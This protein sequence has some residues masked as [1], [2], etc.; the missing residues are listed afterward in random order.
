MFCTNIVHRRRMHCTP[1]IYRYYL[2]HG[3]EFFILFCTTAIQTSPMMLWLPFCS[4]NE[5]LNA[6]RTS[7][8]ERGGGV[9]YDITYKCKKFSKIPK[10]LRMHHMRTFIWLKCLYD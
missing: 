2:K 6:Y 5:I 3:E 10:K 8:L 7:V 4:E 9:T 1:D